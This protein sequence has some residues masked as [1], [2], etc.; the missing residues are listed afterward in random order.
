MKSRNIIKIIALLGTSLTLAGCDFSV[1]PTAKQLQVKDDKTFDYVVG[2]V[3]DNYI[4]N[5][6]MSVTLLYS[7]NSTL[8]LAKTAY[9]YTIKNSNNILM[10]GTKEFEKAGD[11][12][13]TITKDD[14]SPVVHNI[15]VNEK[16][17]P[18]PVTKKLSS[19]SLSGYTETA[20]VGDTY[21]YDGNVSATYSDNSKKFIDLSK[22]TITNPS[23]SKEGES[24]GSVK[25]TED[26]VTK[27][28]TFTINVIKRQEDVVLQSISIESPKT[29][30]TVGDTFT[31]GGTVTATYS[32]GSTSDVT[33][34]A[35]FS[36]YNLSNSGT[37]TVKVSYGGKTTT[38]SITV[39]TAIIAVT[40][41]SL[42]KSSATVTQGETLQLTAT[43]SPTNAT[44]KTVK[45]SGS[46]NNITVNSS[47]L[48]S[49][50]ATATAG[51][52]ATIVATANGN[53]SKTASCVI[54]V[55]AKAV[56]LS[57]I[58]VSNSHREFTVGDTFIK[59]TVTAK[60]SDNS[61]KVVTTA[62]FTG[63]DMKSAGTQTVN[64]SYSENS[65]TKTTSYSITVKTGTTPVS[66]GTITI[67]VSD[68]PTKYDENGSITV[69]GSDK[70]NYS[71]NC[72]NVANYSKN[73]QFKADTG[74]ISNKS[75]LTIKSIELVTLSGSTFVGQL[76]WGD[77]VNPN[78][79]VSV[80]AEN[81]NTYTNP[82]NYTYFKLLN[83]NGSKASY[84]SQ[85]VITLGTN[86][87]I[88][89]TAISLNPTSLSLGL[90]AVSD[91]IAVSY[92]PSDANQ[93]LDITWISSDTTVATV[94]NGVVTAKSKTGSTTIT[95]T[96]Y[97]GIKATCSVTVSDIKVTDISI[98]PSN[99]TVSVGGTTTLTASVTP[100]GASNKN[101]SWSSSKTGV[102]TINSSTGVV[103]GVAAGTTT[104]TATAQDGSGIKATTTLTVSEVKK[105]KWTIMI[106]MCGSTLE[107][108]PEYPTDG[109]YA[110]EDIVEILKS[111]AIPDDV[112][113]LIETGGAGDWELASKYITNGKSSISSSKLQRWEIVSKKDSSS[114]NKLSFVKELNTNQMSSQ[115]SFESFLE[116]GL[117]DY[118]AENTGVIMW[119]HGGAL[120]G[121][122]YDE[123]Y[124]YPYK[125]EYETY[126]YPNSL[127]CSEVAQA[128]KQALANTGGDKMTFIGY[129]ACLMSVA[130]IATVNSDY[131]KYMVASQESEPGYGWDYTTWLNNLYNNKD[132]TTAKIQNVL[133]KICSSFLTHNC[134][135][136]GCGEYDSYYHEYYYCYSTLSV[137]DLSKADAL[138]SAFE[139]YATNIKKIS[140]Y[141]NKIK[142]AFNNAKNYGFGEGIYGVVDFVKFLEYMDKQFSSVSSTN[143]KN[144]I[145]SLVISKYNCDEYNYTP[146]GVNAF[147][148]EITD[149]SGDY[150][151]QC[152]YEDY[153]GEYATKFSTWQEIMLANW[154]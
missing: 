50:S 64:V 6:G 57:S 69:T 136:G 128:T 25:Y 1:K 75:A 144:A 18:T 126:Y 83:Y 116:W 46:S 31:F 56:T 132:N 86:E 94:N 147:V 88:N 95:A 76:H 47:G 114:N 79:S 20:Y 12:K 32:D 19:I 85:I 43:I 151:L 108:D 52:K 141:Y 59:E 118:P 65:V 7:D 148:P 71:F 14:L 34:Q 90:N 134:D 80:D 44:D 39:S 36:G 70:Q 48:V 30:F 8:L 113:I 66:E 99:P 106:Y 133:D 58:S 125:Y 10:D 49:V 4:N 61:T 13:V 67:G 110:S 37:Q 112:N 78:A 129:D 124:T 63:Y 15:T 100:S 97:N 53:T 145:T 45:W 127:N 21:R 142:N 17:D 131:Y 104:I 138:V 146:C 11:Y 40:G 135:N 9:T 120:G 92:T 72:S 51:A 41:I 119:N 82:G 98:S 152:E 81:G 150:G 84:L 24:S 109:G 93:N 38:Y 117:T 102:A 26:G 154:Y 23:T 42:N 16:E 107:Y 55:A 77:S 29:T 2:D 3:F 149:T 111:N 54:T 60:Y 22:C 62:T 74:Y 105:D 143:V 28:E 137:L 89:P 5:G 123:N 101:V 91:K 68:I 139:T 96:G 153:E 87:P 140:G 27:S 115:S 130:D 103:T 35:N 73:M 121:V 122:C 33:R